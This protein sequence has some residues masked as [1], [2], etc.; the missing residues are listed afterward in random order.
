MTMR[1]SALMLAALIMVA[2]FAIPATLAEAPSSALVPAAAPTPTPG[3]AAATL[4]LVANAPLEVALTGGTPID[5]T[6]SGTRGEVI[7]ISARSL[8]PALGLDPT[9]EL[10]DQNGVRLAFN[11]DLN[12][13]RPGFNLLDSVIPSVELLS[14]DVVI[15]RVNTF[16]ANI[17]GP[18]EVLVS[19]DDTLAPTPAAST[20]EY[21]IVTTSQSAVPTD[22]EDCTVVSALAGETLSATVRALNTVLDTT[23]TLLAPDGSPLGFNDDHSKGDASLGRFDSALDSVALPADGDYQLCVSGFGGTSGPYELTIT[24]EA[25]SAALAPTPVPGAQG[26]EQVI[27]DRV[28]EGDQFV[29]TVNWQAGDVYTLTTRALDSAFDPQMGIFAERRNDLLAGNDDHSTSSTD[30]A[31]FDSRITNFIVPE[32]GAYDVVIGGY[33]SS[34][35]PFELTIERTGRGGPLG[36]P[37]VET[38]SGSVAPNGVFVHEATLPEGAYV[39]LR[40]AATAGSTI[41]SQVTLITPDG[42]IA[43]DNDDHTSGDPNLAPTDSLIRNFYV[44]QAGVHTIEVR[45]Y[46]G[47]S[48]AFTLTIETLQ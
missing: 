4:S 1:R 8:N 27:T 43:A 31:F 7:T 29:T 6:Y 32:T 44:A 42:V 11:D 35:G 39:T 2:G 18:V 46:P 3:A 20:S 45:G 23:L 48:G 37:D 12:G 34:G 13:V 38:V 26:D 22:G 19:T 17:S 16:S 36:A 30:L 15:V 24:R 28:P 40:I 41:D 21:P 14:D 25:G 5:L 10:L 9:L 33:E 47:T